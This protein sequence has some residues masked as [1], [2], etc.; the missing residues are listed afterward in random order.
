LPDVLFFVNKGHCA[1]SDGGH[2]R[3]AIMETL[4][5]FQRNISW[6]VDLKEKYRPIIFSNQ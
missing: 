5:D 1:V 4:T 3:I 6:N 2:L